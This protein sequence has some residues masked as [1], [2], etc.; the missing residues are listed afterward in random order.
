MP[1][2]QRTLVPSGASIPGSA[3]GR[4][5]TNDYVRVLLIQLQKNLRTTG[6]IASRRELP[7]TQGKTEG[8]LGPYNP[9]NGL[10]IRAFV[11]ACW[12][13]RPHF[14][15]KAR[16]LKGARVGDHASSQQGWRASVSSGTIGA[17]G[18]LK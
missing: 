6:T 11:V 10:Y 5:E 4:P 2:R 8:R 3:L 14:D 17:K 12:A 15:M 1:H 13:A 7:L 16:I 9:M 18:I